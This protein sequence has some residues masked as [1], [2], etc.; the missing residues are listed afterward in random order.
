MNTELIN[1]YKKGLENGFKNVPQW[2]KDLIV[3]VLDKYGKRIYDYTWLSG[4]ST[5]VYPIEIYR[6]Y[7]EVQVNTKDKRHFSQKGLDS[8]VKSF[9]N[10]KSARFCKYDGS[11]PNSL[12]FYYQK[13]ILA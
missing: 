1:E 5:E 13:S 6:D 9:P 3:C 7:L 10:L 2:L 12:R 4:C 11:C 8:V